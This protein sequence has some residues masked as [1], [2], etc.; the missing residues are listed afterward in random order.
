MLKK[1]A[2]LLAYH[3][4]PGPK[5]GR[6]EVRDAK[7]NERQACGHRRAGRV[8]DRNVSTLLDRP[9]GKRVRHPIEESFGI[10]PSEAGIGDR[11]AVGQRLVGIPAL[12]TALQ[13]AFEHEAHN[14]AAAVLKLFEHFA[15]DFDLALVVLP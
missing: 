9:C 14:R 5:Q 11:H 4:A 6:G 2:F 13:V 10:A 7:N 15:G 1:E 12:S 8:P 3:G